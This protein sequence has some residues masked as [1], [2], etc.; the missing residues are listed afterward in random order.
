MTLSIKGGMDD[1]TGFDEPRYL[2]IVFDGPPSHEGPRFVEVENARGR[3][4]RLGA[5]I[6]RADGYWVLR[7]TPGEVELLT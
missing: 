2:D 7:F 1:T 6:K 4:I 5:W 3:S